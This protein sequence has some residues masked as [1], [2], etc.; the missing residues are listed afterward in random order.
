MEGS[1][2]GEAEGSSASYR[3]G[4]GSSRDGDRCAIG[5]LSL[6]LISGLGSRLEHDL[7]QFFLK[8]QT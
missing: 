5:L 8:I 7:D 6:Y 2:D 4:D 3:D 1:L